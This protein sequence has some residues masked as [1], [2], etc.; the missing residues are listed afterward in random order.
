MGSL[1]GAAGVAGK[2]GSGKSST[3]N[4]I[5]CSKAF[6]PQISKLLRHSALPQGLRDFLGR[7]LTVLDPPGACWTPSSG[8]WRCSRSSEE[9]ALMFPGPHVFLLVVPVGRF[10]KAEQESVRSE[11]RRQGGAAGVDCLISGSRDLAE[12]VAKCRGRYCVFNNRAV[13][14]KEQVSELLALVDGVLEANEGGCF[15][16]V[17]LRE[18][19]EKLER[20]REEAARALREEEQRRKQEQEKVSREWYQGQ[21]KQVELKSVKEMEEMRRSQRSDRART[22]TVVREKEDALR[23]AREENAKKEKEW[24][25]QEVMQMWR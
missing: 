22:E 25:I 12:L 19:E 1:H 18:A 13:K 11:S 15:T 4:S 2:T 8:P 3:G 9:R 14:N 17:M 20:A 23:L 16:S 21:L 10:T 7:H 24:K 5:L 6:Q